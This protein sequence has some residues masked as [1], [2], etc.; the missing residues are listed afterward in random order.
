MR[1]RYFKKYSN[2]NNLEA[3]PPIHSVAGA[4]RAIVCLLAPTTL[5]ASIDSIAARSLLHEERAL[6][7]TGHR[8]NNMTRE[9]APRRG[10]GSDTYAQIE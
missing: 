3:A 5:T 1:R 7:R 6:P 10:A 8:A 2:N 9:G 4:R